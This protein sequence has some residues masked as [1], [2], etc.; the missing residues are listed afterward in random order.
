MKPNTPPIYTEKLKVLPKGMLWVLLI[1]TLVL[2]ELPLLTHWESWELAEI[3]PSAGVLAFMV[4]IWWFALSCRIKL[5]L[6]AEGVQY[7]FWI[8]PAKKARWEELQGW[9]VREVVSFEEFGGWGVRYGFNLGWGYVNTSAWGLQLDFKNEKRVVISTEQ[10]EALNEW[11]EQW[12]PA[13][14]VE[15]A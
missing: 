13:E 8:L 2:L 9:Y 4:L 6:D 1:A 3:R 14:E 15:T 11:L 10:P 5:R 7:Q 12:A